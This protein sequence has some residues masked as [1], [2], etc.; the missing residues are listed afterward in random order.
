MKN[1]N[2]KKNRILFTIILLTILIIFSTFIF[3]CSGINSKASSQG[4]S[5]SSNQ[6]NLPSQDDNTT[7]SGK[8]NNEIKNVGVDDVFNMLKDK[9]KYFLLDVRTQ[10]EYKEGFIENSI[11][12]PVSELE[13]R[14]SE[15]P[16]DK[17]V[18]VYCRSGNR[19][20]QAAEIL[21][22]NNFNS[23]YNMLGGITEWVKKGYPVVK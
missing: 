12:I 22:K 8:V 2:Y 18:I 20:A 17:P 19:S 16:S 10:E 23:V 1:F 21:L 6:E 14:L 7:Q 3:S 13:N 5:A 11:L 4:I 15:I 9:N